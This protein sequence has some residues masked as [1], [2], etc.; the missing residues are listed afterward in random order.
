LSS[1]WIVESPMPRDGRAITISRSLDG[2][3]NA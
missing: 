2:S 3:M 1:S